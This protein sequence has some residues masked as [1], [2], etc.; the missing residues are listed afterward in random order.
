MPEARVLGA[1]L[2]A[3]ML[4]MAS[5]TASQLGR[6]PVVVLLG[7]DF[8]DPRSEINVRIHTTCFGQVG[9]RVRNTLLP[10]SEGV[11]DALLDLVRGANDDPEV[12]GVMVLLPL[13][14]D[15]DVRRVIST[16]DPDKEVEGLHVE[17]IMRNHPLAS[18][19]AVPAPPPIVPQATLALLGELGFPMTDLH[20]AIVTSPRMVQENPVSRAITGGGVSSVLPLDATV[21]VVPCTSP[22]GRQVTT[23][24][25]LLLVSVD[26]PRVIDGSWVKQGALVI[27]YNAMPDPDPA[28]SGVVGGVD[29]GSVLA[30]GAS[31]APIPG[32]FG[33]VLLGCAA[34]RIVQMSAR[35]QSLEG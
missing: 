21:S 31:V 34:L 8:G 18:P 12:D 10:Y 6:P 25:D 11:E 33:P 27:D 15:V 35:R 9:I 13:P 7:I 4:A 2:K 5:A 22:G 26:E 1:P 24:A 20:V 30:A 28:R 29:T 16:I 3:R 19:S 23:M 32:G 17:A 14:R